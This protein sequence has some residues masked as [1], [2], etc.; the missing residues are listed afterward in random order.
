[1]FPEAIFDMML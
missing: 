1:M